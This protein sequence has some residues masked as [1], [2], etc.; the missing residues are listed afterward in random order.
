MSSVQVFDV[1]AGRKN[2]LRIPALRISSQLPRRDPRM[3]FSGIEG[4]LINDGWDVIVLLKPSAVLSK[5]CFQSLD[6]L[7]VELPWLVPLEM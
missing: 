2:Q 6:I 3:L 5:I 7:T 4:L 1:I